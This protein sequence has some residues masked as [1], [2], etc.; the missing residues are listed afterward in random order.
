M[1]FEPET[2]AAI[3]LHPRSKHWHFLDYVITRA[4]DVADVHLTRVMRGAEAECWTD[5]RLVVSNFQLKIFPAAGN[6]LCVRTQK[7]LNVR[8]CKDPSTQDK[9]Q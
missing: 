3:W 8:A 4:R 2:L 6:M 7:R 1:G 5:H 9:L